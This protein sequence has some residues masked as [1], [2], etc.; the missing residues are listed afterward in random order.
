M[1][2]RYNTMFSNTGISIFSYLE[3]NRYWNGHCLYFSDKTVSGST[4]MSKKICYKMNITLIFYPLKSPFPKWISFHRILEKG[5]LNT[6][7]NLKK[8]NSYWFCRFA[9]F[10]KNVHSTL[11]LSKVVSLIVSKI[12]MLHKG[13]IYE[14]KKLL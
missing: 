12:P 2:E 5:F 11:S 10:C 13:R 4:V 14:N 3:C 6:M 1:P 9:C 8:K 7:V